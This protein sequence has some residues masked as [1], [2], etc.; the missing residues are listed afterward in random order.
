MV[1]PNRFSV[2]QSFGNED[3]LKISNGPKSRA[4]GPRP[5]KNIIKEAM[6]IRGNLKGMFRSNAMDE[7]ISKILRVERKFLG[8]EISRLRNSPKPLLSER[9]AAIAAR[10]QRIKHLSPLRLGL[11]SV[12]DDS[13]LV[14]ERDSVEVDT[15]IEHDST[16]GGEHMVGVDSSEAKQRSAPSLP[17][18]NE[19]CF[20][21]STSGSKFLC[22]KLVGVADGLSPGNMDGCRKI[23]VGE[24]GGPLGHAHE[25]FDGLPRRAS[26]TKSRSWASSVGGK[27]LVAHSKPSDTQGDLNSLCMGE[28]YS[29]NSG[30]NIVQ[31]SG[32]KSNK[33]VI[34]SP[35]VEKVVNGFDLVHKVYGEGPNVGASQMLDT[36]PQRNRDIAVVQQDQP[37]S[38]RTWANIV[39][40]PA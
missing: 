38:K 16:S 39:G 4:R 5:G 8:S 23:Q 33:P 9:M 31:I 24:K 35:I 26:V 1:R 14:E 20:P 29:P 10:I 34:V 40:C 21:E 12:G 6:S 28:V 15:K 17:L 11:K 3:D 27:N 13:G 30:T 25:V 7:E 37:T 18:V 32:D 19:A 36:M 2:L 22:S